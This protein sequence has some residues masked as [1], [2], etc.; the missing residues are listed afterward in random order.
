MRGHRQLGSSEMK[1]SELQRKLK[2]ALRKL[3]IR[4]KQT[5]GLLDQVKEAYEIRIQEMQ[6][7]GGVSQAGWGGRGR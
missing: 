7:N 6:C 3:D 5:N 1:V 4:K 2:D